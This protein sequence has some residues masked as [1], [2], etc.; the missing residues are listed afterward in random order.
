M[1]EFIGYI[2][3]ITI[4]TSRGLRYYWGR[5][6][7][8]KILPNYF[9]SGVKL[10]KWIYSKTNGKI[11]YPYSMSI[12]IA[13]KL[14]LT[15][16]ILAY[17]YTIEE[18]YQLEKDII[19]PHLGKEYCQNLIEG[20]KNSITYGHKGHKC[21]EET[22]QKISIAKKGKKLSK[23]A[24]I[25]ISKG[26]LG[27]PS[28]KGML[29]KHHS[30]ESIIKAKETKKKR[31]TYRKPH[32]NETIEKIKISKQNI[33][34]ETRQK[35]SNAAKLRKRHKHTNE[36]KIHMRQ[37]RLGNKN[38]AFGRKWYNNG[39]IQIFEKEC[40]IGFIPG[41]LSKKPTA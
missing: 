28:P 32:S 10:K 23:K 19:A 26:H 31:G 27:I 24:R 37:I 33:S 36:E 20:G 38:P 22:K 2:Y 35:M 34:L 14:G 39:I 16:E 41:R 29:G 15:R 40:P 7:S 12:K 6:I 11:K 25:N 3:K 9:G 13:K 8:N 1:K 5:K 17:A 4:P 30:P 18:L 21:S